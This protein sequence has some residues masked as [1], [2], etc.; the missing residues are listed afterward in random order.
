MFDKLLKKLALTCSAV[1]LLASWGTA[2]A[3]PVVTS[4]GDFANVWTIEYL[5]NANQVVA[6]GDVYWDIFDHGGTLYFGFSIV[7][8]SPANTSDTTIVGFAWD[9]PTGV[10]MSNG[11]SSL[12]WGFGFG[13]QTLPSEPLAFDA[14]TYGG[15]NCGAGTNTGINVGD[16]FN[17]FFV[18]LTTQLDLSGLQ[19]AFADSRACLRF[20]AG[21]G[22]TACRDETSTGEVVEGT[23]VP[24]PESLALLGIGL[25][26]LSLRNSRRA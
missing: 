25:L 9:A 21:R 22:N 26:L 6:S 5:S 3:V 16:G 17:S 19:S 18:E 14:C 2:G 11:W 4:T 8:T 12:G 1:A 15:Q 13:G 7:N 24:E 10:T 20:V 23:E